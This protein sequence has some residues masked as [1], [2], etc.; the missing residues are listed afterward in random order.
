MRPYEVVITGV[1]LGPAWLWGCNPAGFEGR[2]ASF[3]LASL[4]V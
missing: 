2:L 1:G 3:Q 4:D